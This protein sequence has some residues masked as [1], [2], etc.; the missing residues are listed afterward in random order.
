MMR[1]GELRDCVALVTGAGS[2]I[3]R[4]IAVLFAREAAKVVV[5]DLSE[6]DGKSTVELIR[7]DN[8]DTILV[9]GDVSKGDSVKRMVKVSVEEFGKLNVL[10]NNAGVESTGSVV[11]LSEEDWDKVM[12]INLKGTFLCSKYCAPR[13]VES[14]GGAIINVA[15]VLGLIGSKGE[16]AY[17]ASKGGIISLSRAMALDFA[18][19]NVRVNCLCPGSVLTPTFKR[20]MKASGQYDAAFARNLKKIPLGRVADPEEIAQAALFLASKKSSYM[21]GATLVI[22]AGWSVS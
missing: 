20:V 14:G 10:V 7:K 6:V 15:S 9:Q 17:C 2:G 4:A 19:Q 5:A 21:T 16:A 3:G 13:I 12:R 11:D 8:G 18:S 1:Q 22:D